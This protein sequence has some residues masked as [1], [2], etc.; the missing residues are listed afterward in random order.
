MLFEGTLRKGHE[1]PLIDALMD[2]GADLDFQRER[3]DG[4]KSDTPLIGAASLG[5]EE[6][7]LRVL[8][9]EARPELRGLFGE[10]ALHW[11]A[12]GRGASGG[13]AD[14]RFRLNLKDGKYTPL[15]WDGRCT[16]VTT[17]PRA[18]MDVSAKWQPCSFA[19]VR[20]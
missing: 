12:A 3:E 11:I 14:C 15:R 5:T 8:S 19:R 7:G 1:L 13:G 16:D 4:G 20:R 17:L 2:A 6:A 18:I 10:T 9:V